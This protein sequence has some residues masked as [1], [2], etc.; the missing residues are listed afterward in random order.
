M[1]SNNCVSQRISKY[2]IGFL[3]LGAALG[4]L[5][6]GVTIL[7]VFGFIMALP[8]LALAVI[9]FRLHLNDQCEIDF[10]S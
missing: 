4:L 2:F 8:V 6:I 5:V 10:P 3:A 1:R 7:P 9:I